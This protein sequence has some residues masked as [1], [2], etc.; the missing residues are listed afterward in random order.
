LPSNKINKTI[1]QFKHDI[2]TKYYFKTE[3]PP[4]DPDFNPKLYIKAPW[5]KPK[6]ASQV[7]EDALTLFEERLTTKHN[8]HQVAC[9][10]NIT[11]CKT[12]PFES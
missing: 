4:E 1:E 12:V 7:I 11:F 8:K 2:Q 10:P 9:D 6:P 3:D 5:W